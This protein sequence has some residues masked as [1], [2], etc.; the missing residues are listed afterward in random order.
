MGCRKPVQPL[1]EVLLSS[2]NALD[3]P[4]RF[5]WYLS[6]ELS[7]GENLKA[8][9]SLLADLAAM[10]KDRRIITAVVRSPEKGERQPDSL[11]PIPATD[12]SGNLVFLW[13]SLVIDWQDK[14]IVIPDIWESG[15]LS[16]DLARGLQD[17]A[18]GGPVQ[19]GYL[20]GS[21]KGNGLPMSLLEGRWDTGEWFPGVSQAKEFD[22]LLIRDGPALDSIDNLLSLLLRYLEG[23]G[24]ILIAGSALQPESSVGSWASSRERE[25]SLLFIDDTDFLNP[26]VY[27]DGR[28]S[29][30]DIDTALLMASG[31]KDLIAMMAADITGIQTRG[32]DSA[33]SRL[34]KAASSPESMFFPESSRIEKIIFTGEDTIFSLEKIDGKWILISE[35]WQ[36]P[37]RSDRIESFLE[38]LKIGSEN[39]WKVSD[40]PISSG[41]LEIVFQSNKG[42]PVL[43]EPAGE[44]QA[45]GGVYFSGEDGLVLWPNLNA[46]DVSGDARYWMERRLFPDTPEIIRAELSSNT[47]LYW[48]LHEETGQWFLTGRDGS[49]RILDK[50][51][52]L[53]FSERLLGSESL[54]I[55]PTEGIKASPLFLR[56][57]DLMGRFTEYRLTDTAD[58]RVAAVSQSGEF[59]HILDDK[60]VEFILS[61][62]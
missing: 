5:T 43:F 28:R 2:L 30:R 7:A 40:A 59:L 57:E 47:H 44:R 46:A 34:V 53:E 24:R 41:N 38:R 36:L 29:F 35:D 22:I 12:G 11:L 51:T 1:P 61:G 13:S 18:A 49:R 54:T 26:S 48:R 9:D 10:E 16:L 14:R 39:L 50:K 31:R 32:R 4:I 56:I 42:R 55:A 62:P 19:V 23:G 52:A 3:G 21:E 60:L 45:G 17:L 20:D 58:G 37:S 27:E 33:G 25:G 6:P 8:A 15:W